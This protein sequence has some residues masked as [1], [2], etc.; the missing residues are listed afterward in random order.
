M[1]SKPTCAIWS[2]RPSRCSVRRTSIVTRFCAVNSAVGR[3]GPG[4]QRLDVVVH[5][6]RLRHRL[7]VAGEPFG[8]RVEPVRRRAHERD[9]LVPVGAQMLDRGAGAAAVVGEHVVG[10]DRLRG[11]V[12][13]HEPDARRDVALEVRVVV[14][15]RDEDEP[16]HAPPEHALHQLA[17]TLRV[18]VRAAGER[19]HRPLARDLLHPAMDGGEEGV[20]D[21][22]E[23]QGDRGRE[24]VRPPQRARR[25]VVAVAEQLDRALA[26]STASSGSTGGLPLTTRETVLRLTP[27]I[28]A[29]SFMV[30]RRAT[31]HDGAETYADRPARRDGQRGGIS[32]EPRTISRVGSTTERGSGSGRTAA[33]RRGGR[34]RTDPGPRRSRPAG[35]GRPGRRRRSRRAPPCVDGRARAAPGSRRS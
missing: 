11:A 8:G 27:A 7:V 33:P 24:P 31:G 1:S 9:P 10:V 13:E 12:H 17:L 2:W 19:H 30:G 23:D 20:A 29:T 3:S 18:G 28:E 26:P 35:R 6:Q 22:L 32:P 14:R 4:E 16:V 21:V 15:G 34:A 5:D 25:V